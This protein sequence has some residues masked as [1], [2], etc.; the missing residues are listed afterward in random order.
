MTLR[1]SGRRAPAGSLGV[2][3]CAWWAAESWPGVVRGPRARDPLGRLDSRPRTGARGRVGRA[4]DSKEWVWSGPGRQRHKTARF[5]LFSGGFSPCSVV[6]TLLIRAMIPVLK[7]PPS[8]GS[9]PGGLTDQPPSIHDDSSFLFDV[10]C[11][12]PKPPFG[13]GWRDGQQA[14]SSAVSGGARSPD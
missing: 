4:E 2:M 5:G 14:G 9:L 12:D 3:S 6:Q 10:R 13:I 1:G 8:H 7:K 11:S